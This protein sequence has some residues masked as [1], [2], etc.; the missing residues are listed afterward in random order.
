M[1]TAPIAKSIITSRK[2]FKME[3]VYDT[4]DTCFLLQVSEPELK[5]W[6]TRLGISLIVKDNTNWYR[7]DDIIDVLAVFVYKTLPL[8]DLSDLDSY[9]GESI[10]WL[11]EKELEGFE[12]TFFTTDEP[13]TTSIFLMSFIKHAEV[14]EDFKS[15]LANRSLILKYEGK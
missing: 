4:E 8:N 5:D 13:I 15:I 9:Y 10:Y 3:I 7:R 2:P 1:K 6:C 12:M 14:S 11:L